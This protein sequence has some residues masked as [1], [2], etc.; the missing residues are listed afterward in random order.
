MTT[1]TQWREARQAALC[2]AHDG[3]L[4]VAIRKIK[5]YGHVRFAVSFAARMDSDFSRA[6]IVYPE[7]VW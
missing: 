7:D 3:N 4:P 6:E 5:E 1:Y 2:K